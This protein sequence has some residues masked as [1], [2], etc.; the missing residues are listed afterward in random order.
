MIFPTNESKRV[1]CK[2]DSLD[3]AVNVTMRMNLKEWNVN[4]GGVTGSSTIVAE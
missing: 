1:E 2:C 3:T 4:V